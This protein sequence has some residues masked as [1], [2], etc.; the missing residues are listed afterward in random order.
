MVRFFVL[1]PIGSFSVATKQIMNEEQ[2]T[3]HVDNVYKFSPST[4]VSLFDSPNLSGITA[5]ST[6][7]IYVYCAMNASRETI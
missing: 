5:V 4:K 7:G 3:F 6:Y 2:R 1:A